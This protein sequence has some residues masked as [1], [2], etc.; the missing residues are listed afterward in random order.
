MHFYVVL[1]FY[2]VRRGQRG[3]QVGP[4]GSEPVSEPK[5]PQSSPTRS[6]AGGQPAQRRRWAGAGRGQPAQRHRR[7]GAAY[8]EPFVGCRFTHT[9]RRILRRVAKFDVSSRLSSALPHLLIRFRLAEFICNQS[10]PGSKPEPESGPQVWIQPE[11]Q[12][13]TAPARVRAREQ[14]RATTLA[15]I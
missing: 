1:A 9:A 3:A 4:G 8:R 11:P 14:A 6:P 12:P 15:R 7:A 13:Q 10:E 2:S 5:C